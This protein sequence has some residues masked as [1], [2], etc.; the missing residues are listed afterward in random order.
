MKCKKPIVNQMFLNAGFIVLLSGPPGN[1]SQSMGITFFLLTGSRA[2]DTFYF[3]HFLHFYFIHF[4]VTSLSYFTV[5]AW[6]AGDTLGSEGTAWHASA[7]YWHS[8]ALPWRP[9]FAPWDPPLRSTSCKW[10]GVI[11]NV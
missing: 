3:S 8:N 4:K 5:R 6:C 1:Q 9:K 7:M 2:R 11:L 10:E